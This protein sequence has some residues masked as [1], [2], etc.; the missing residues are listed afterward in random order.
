[1]KFQNTMMIRLNKFI[2]K[3]DKFGN[4]YGEMDDDINI[5]VIKK[6]TIKKSLKEIAEKNEIKINVKYAGLTTIK[7]VINVAQKRAIPKNMS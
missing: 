1:M 5:N 2:K 6:N 3:I 7:N 4:Q